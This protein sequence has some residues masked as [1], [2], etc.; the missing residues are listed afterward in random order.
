MLIHFALIYFAENFSIK[1]GNRFAGL[2]PSPTSFAVWITLIY[3]VSF[4]G[5][6][7][8]FCSERVGQLLAVMGF[9][10][11]SLLVF[12]SK[13]RIN[14]AYMIL[15]FLIL[16]FKRIIFKKRAIAS[17]VFFCFCAFIFISYYI[18]SSIFCRLILV[19]SSRVT[20]AG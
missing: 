1:L 8:G 4:S 11:V 12:F 14:F 16:M 10:M 18:Y 7:S 19:I 15:I 5:Q 20:R 9:V 17:L 6:L 13:T 3:I 2:H